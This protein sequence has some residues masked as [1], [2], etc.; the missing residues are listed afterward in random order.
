MNAF[1]A[2]VLATAAGVYQCLHPSIDESDRSLLRRVWLEHDL[3]NRGRED[4]AFRH[5]LF[6]AILEL[7]H[8]HQL[9]R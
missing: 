9:T 8:I 7:H 2:L 1:Q 6:Y 5:Q 3:E 4:R